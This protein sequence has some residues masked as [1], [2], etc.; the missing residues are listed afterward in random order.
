MKFG[1][2][3]AC[4]LL[5]GAFC[6]MSFGMTRVF[7]RKP[8]LR[9]YQ[10]LSP[11]RR[12]IQ[13]KAVSEAVK[14]SPALYDRIQQTFTEF[15]TAGWNFLTWLTGRPSQAPA[16][17]IPQSQQVLVEPLSTSVQTPSTTPTSSPTAMLQHIRQAELKTS[18]NI[19]QEIAP[20]L[21]AIELSKEKNIVEKKET[22]LMVCTPPGIEIDF[23]S[24]L[25]SFD[26]IINFIKT[27][28][29]KILID[30]GLNKEEVNNFLL[31]LASDQRYIYQNAYTI[32]NKPVIHDTTLDPN[33]LQEIIIKLRNAGINPLCVNII[34]KPEKEMGDGFAMASSPLKIKESLQG[35]STLIF[36]Q[37]LINTK[38]RETVAFAIGHEIGHLILCHNNS[39]YQVKERITTMLRKKNGLSEFEERKWIFRNNK[40]IEINRNPLSIEIE[41]TVNQALKEIKTLA[42]LE[43]DITYSLYDK[44]IAES[45]LKSAQ[46][47]ISSGTSDTATMLSDIHQSINMRYHW[48]KR[49]QDLHKAQEAAKE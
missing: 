37:E 25:E 22:A 1:S 38:P 10:Q 4:F 43:A 5:L 7:M 45:S 47:V 18:E 14:T 39:F 49:I 17:T 28:K 44:N 27:L 19:A 30:T 20:V 24:A 15:K 32:P 13:T 46:T 33:I 41:N 8:P 34:N 2:K 21:K 29:I 6:N 42:E 11:Q 16:I 26:A 12:M 31:Q 40:L 9:Q 48:F 3:I 35:Q 36:S 23:I